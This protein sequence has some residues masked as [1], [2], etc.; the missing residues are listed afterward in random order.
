MLRSHHGISQPAST[1][2][3]GLLILGWA[4][5][6]AATL[7]YGIAHLGKSL[8]WYTSE[9]L[10]A[11]FL[12]EFVGLPIDRMGVVLAIGFVISAAIDLGVGAGL[13]ARLTTARSASRIQFIGSIIC[14]A[15]LIAVF[16]GA[17]MP[18]E[19]RYGYA[20]M[21]G[22]AFRLGFA[23]YDIPQNTLMVLATSDAANRRR[24]A[25]VRIW[26]SGT[27]TL[28][29]AATVGPLIAR[30][31]QANG[32]SFLLMVAILFAILAIG[33]AWLLA[34]LFRDPQLGHPPKIAAIRILPLGHGIAAFWLLLLV[35]AAT[36]IFTPAFAKLEPY[37]AT[38]TL[39]SAWWG[40]AVVTLMAAGIVVGQ[41]IW[42]YMLARMSAGLVMLLNALLKLAGLGAFWVVGPSYPVA[43]AAAAFV[44]GLGNGGVG[45][46]QWAS[47]SEAVA[48]FDPSRTGLS[49][50]LFGATGKVSLA[51]GG[52]LL[53]TALDGADGGDLTLLMAVI[54]A[55]G[56]LVCALAGIGL[57]VIEDADKRAMRVLLR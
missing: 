9:I 13:A 2:E 23:A 27:A 14:S 42:I 56:A 4:D 24:I 40:G 19:L 21:T 47:F 10:F 34:R 31:Y 48:R 41:P 22:I 12:T 50:G 33:S 15:S 25:S 43:A 16:L 45:V 6:W 57:V 51:I 55:I 32:A 35:M 11:F 38:Y 54:P 18:V 17:R 7:T 28:I 26:F 36:S 37:F 8:F 46:V 1:L 49:Y 20:I 30:R 39:R 3:G 44:F 5:S 52:I 29:V 53:A